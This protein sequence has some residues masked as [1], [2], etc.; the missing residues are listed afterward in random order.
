MGPGE[1]WQRVFNGD[2]A[3]VWGD[4]KVLGM[5]EVVAAQQCDCA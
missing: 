2:S 1:G 3:S 5:M 4:E